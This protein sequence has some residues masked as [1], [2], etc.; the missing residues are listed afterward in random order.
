MQGLLNFKVINMK[1][2]YSLSIERPKKNWQ[3]NR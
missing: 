1:D 3:Q 2:I